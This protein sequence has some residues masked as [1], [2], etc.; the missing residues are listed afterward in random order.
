MAPAAGPGPDPFADLAAG[1][2]GRYELLGPLGQG[3]MAQVLRA[4]DLKH[5]REVALKVLHPDLGRSLGAERFQQEI[6]LTATLQHP[7]LVSVFDSG[8]TAGHLWYTMPLVAGESLRERLRRERQLPLAD[9]LRIARDTARA[10]AAAHG[11]G[12]VHRDLKPENLLLTSD[13][14]VMVADFGLARARGDA[15]LTAAGLSVGTPLYMAP[16]QAGGGA[17]PD[18]RSDVYALGCI[19][20]EMLAGEPPFPGSTPQS[21]LAKHLHAPVPEI[22][23]VRPTVPPALHGLLRSALAK[24]PADRTPTAAALAEAL[25]R[26][27]AGPGRT[28]AWRR[29]WPALLALPLGALLLFRGVGRPAAVAAPVAPAPA[30]GGQVRI[31]VLY[32]TTRSPDSVSRRVADGFTE[33]LIGELAGVHAFELVPRSAVWAYR[34]RTVLFDSMVHALRP[35]VVVD[36]SVELQG[37]QAQVRVDLLDAA[38]A[39]SLEHL[40]LVQPL[41]PGPGR[42]GALTRQVAEALR[43]QLGR[44]AREARIMAG[45]TSADARGL[46]ARAERARQ[47]AATMAAQPHA[48]DVK[49]ARQALDHADSLLEAAAQADRRWPRP[50]IERGWV[51]VERTA[52][53]PESVQAQA[54]AAALPQAEAALRRGPADAEA[55]ALRGTLQWRMETIFEYAL[56]DSARLARAEA[57]L[58]AAVARDSSLATAWATLSYLVGGNGAYAEAAL[59]ARHALEADAYLDD[60]VQ[61]YQQLFFSELYLEHFAEAGEWC[62]RGR[63]EFPGDWRFLQCELTLLR[64]QVTAPPRPDSAWALVAQLERLD[65]AARGVAAGRPYHSIFRRVAAATV[66]A[67]AG[68][69]ARAR[70][71]LARARRATAGARSLQLDLAYD[72]AC[73]LLTLG[74]REAAAG[75]LRELAA[76]RPV[77]APLLRRD[78]LFRGVSLP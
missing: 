45:T 25:E 15:A 24:V 55:L 72:E 33:E 22:R 28:V 76:A 9:A 48:E 5:G 66:S 53:L 68:D 52:L 71:E 60:A 41:R 39:A 46:V 34:D 26:V 73:L 3:S 65:P 10:V 16:E 78:P 29:W 62:R 37:D 77:L 75:R 56:P 14:Q 59:Y 43:R 38:T 8:E 47:D 57:D 30:P 50:L 44:R 4:R 54:L 19:L 12:I 63:V 32:F 27:A 11:R 20:Y 49:S 6:R 64:H 67:R 69:T 42:E 36:G 18:P 35:S 17:E 21:V 1:L 31:A 23:I 74:E 7:N 61:V 51:A 58:R 70:A 13:G 2:A 40:S